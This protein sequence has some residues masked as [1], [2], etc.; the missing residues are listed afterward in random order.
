LR[1]PASPAPHDLQR[2]FPSGSIQ[3]TYQLAASAPCFLIL[4][5]EGHRDSC[6]AL[7]CVPTDF[8]PSAR[9]FELLKIDLVRVGNG[10]SELYRGERYHVLVNGDCSECECLGYLRWDRP[11]KHLLALTQLVAEGV[12]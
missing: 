3:P 8:G 1:W 5:E 4:S 2:R 7:R 11:C 10:P 6:Y 12:L 9:G